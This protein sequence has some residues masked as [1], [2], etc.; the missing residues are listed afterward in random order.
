MKRLI[1][2]A[3]EQGRCPA[4]GEHRAEGMQPILAQVGARR[5]TPSFTLLVFRPLIG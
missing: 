4:Q 1:T 5:N 3:R 2:G